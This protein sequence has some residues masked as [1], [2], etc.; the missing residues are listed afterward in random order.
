MEPTADRRPPSGSD[1]E[2][3]LLVLGSTAHRA[4][5]GRLGA[6]LLTCLRWPSCP[7]VAVQ[8]ALIPSFNDGVAPS[9]GSRL[10]PT[11]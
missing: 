4:G 6:I 2:A 11:R 9:C 7:V 5:D 3:D 10:S 1:S 8:P